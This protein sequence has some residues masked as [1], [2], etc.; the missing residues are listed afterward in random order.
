M[1]S[2]PLKF[3]MFKLGC[4]GLVFRPWST[5]RRGLSPP[6]FLLQAEIILSFIAIV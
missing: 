3:D 1:V 6:I 5:E 2:K 4:I